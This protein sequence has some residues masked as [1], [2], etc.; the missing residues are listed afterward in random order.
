M[1]SP[2]LVLR[3]E[4]VNPLDLDHLE[5]LLRRELHGRLIQIRLL[6]RDEGLVLQG[7]SPSFYGK[8]LAQHAIM[9]ATQIPIRANEIHVL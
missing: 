1:E 9:K 6:F 5:Q 4:C 2:N 7:E 3:P 8:Q